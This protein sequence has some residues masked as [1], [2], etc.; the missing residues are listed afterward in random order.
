MNPNRILIVDDEESV[1]Y[2]FKRLLQGD[3]LPL[4]EA[5]D[6]KE[7]ISQLTKKHYALV[8]L[9][10]NLPDISGLTLLKQIKEID[11]KQVVLI[12]TAYGTTET[13]IEA[14]RLGAYDYI[15]KPFDI[16]T[17]QNTVKEA[18]KS[19]QLMHTQV[20]I[21]SSEDISEEG[22]QLIG[23]SQEMQEVYKMIGRVAGTDINILLRG[24]SGTGKELVA[25]AIYQY[26][27]REQKP[28]IAVNCAAIPETLLESELFGY[29]KGAFTGANRRKIGKFELANGGTIFLDEIGDMSL[30]TQTKILRVLQE[31]TFERLGAELSVAVDVRVIAATNRNLE[32]LIDEEKFRED[33]YYRIK[34]IT[35]TLPP[36]RFRKA[37]VP[38]LAAY[39]LRKH[40]H[41]SDKKKYQFASEAL[42]KMQEY[43]WP[44][45]IREL[46]NIIKR[47]MVL[48]KNH[49]ISAELVEGEFQHIKEGQRTGISSPAITSFFRE[50]K[51]KSSGTMYD[52]ILS[53]IEKELIIFTLQ[54][55]NGNQVKAAKILGI[56]RMMLRDRIDKYNISKSYV[57][58]NGNKNLG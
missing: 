16:P 26:S 50:I 39:F 29:E 10:I 35:I 3:A 19:S 31:G 47:A 44:G 7:A 22:D 23:K 42:L 25:R 18:L 56:S 14:I 45:N 53:M 40:S 57:I 27:K 17:I 52:T 36:L 15:L 4:D 2:S 24:E 51:D 1:R 32:K 54:E 38:E 46:E 20:S 37:D 28:F 13:A 34:V 12:I 9:D 30:L 5:R 49:I 33:L 8:I 21:E 43:Q 41:L 55:T 48:S 11:P 6:G 58:K